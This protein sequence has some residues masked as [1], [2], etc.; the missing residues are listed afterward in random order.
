MGD[1]RRHERRREVADDLWA[2]SYLN[3]SIFLNL[4][5]AFEHLSQPVGFSLGSFYTHLA[6]ACDLVEDFLVR[7]HLP[8]SEC[9]GERCLAS[10]TFS[11]QR[12]L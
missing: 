1:P 12:Q 5:G 10:T 4:V 2:I 8:I 3:Y 11:G 9:R 7:V 6:S